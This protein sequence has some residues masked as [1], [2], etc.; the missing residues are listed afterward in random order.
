MRR[1]IINP[2]VQHPSMHRPTE[3][4]T[5]I[6]FI[7]PESTSL[8]VLVNTDPLIPLG[9]ILCYS[10]IYLD[11]L[12]ISAVHILS[13]QTWLKLSPSHESHFSGTSSGRTCSLTTVAKLFM[14]N[15]SAQRHGGGTVMVWGWCDS[16]ERCHMSYYGSSQIYHNASDS[17]SGLRSRSRHEK[18]LRCMW[19][20][21]KGV[22]EMM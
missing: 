10:V 19:G 21:G 1:P 13:Y 5:C 17:C 18:P 16:W 7:P 15:L 8:S 12:V 4:C 11:L 3:E 22:E 14:V 9:H 6:Y 20:S 2:S